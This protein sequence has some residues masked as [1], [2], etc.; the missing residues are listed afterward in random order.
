MT[1]KVLLA[2]IVLAAQ[3][4]PLAHEARHRHTDAQGG[5]LCAPVPEAGLLV[6]ARCDRSAP[7]SRACDTPC[8]PNRD[9]ALNAGV[10]SFATH[11]LC[12]GVS[13]AHAPRGPPPRRSPSPLDASGG[14]VPAIAWDQRWEV[15]VQFDANTVFVLAITVGFFGLI[16]WAEIRLRRRRPQ[17]GDSAN[18]AAPENAP[19]PPERDKQ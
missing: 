10:R 14:R 6:S 13:R 4:G 17:P 12:G 15:Y 1:T 11:R 16:A 7:P 5:T 3:A 19:L 2:I 8:V 9:V 18:V